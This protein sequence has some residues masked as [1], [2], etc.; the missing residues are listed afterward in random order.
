[1]VLD[2]LKFYKFNFV[3]SNPPTPLNEFE[4]KLAGVRMCCTKS[5]DLHVGINF[6]FD[7]FCK[8][9]RSYR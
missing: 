9:Y 6:M 1:M 2:I 5:L 4:W 8:S 3:F 7:K